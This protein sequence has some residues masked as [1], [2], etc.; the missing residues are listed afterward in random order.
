MNDD[1]ILAI[2]V[3]HADLQR[4]AIAGR[5]DEHGQVIIHVDLPDGGADSMP[6]VGIA[7]SVLADRRTDPHRGTLSFRAYRVNNCCLLITLL[8][9]EEHPALA[10]RPSAAR[11]EPCIQSLRSVSPRS[12]TRYRTTRWDPG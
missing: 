2:Q 10:P 12:M 6:D 5:A 11:I 4:R 8:C 9:R 7:H 3:K 1:R